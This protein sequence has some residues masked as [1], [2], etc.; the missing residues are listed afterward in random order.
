MPPEKAA[1]LASRFAALF[2]APRVYRG[3]GWGDPRHIFEG[4]V[5]LVDETRAGLLLI[6]ES[7]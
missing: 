7:D 3:L 6:V 4:G 5:L 1:E 2:Q